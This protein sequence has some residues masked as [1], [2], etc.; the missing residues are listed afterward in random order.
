MIMREKAYLYVLLLHAVYHLY[1]PNT[2][3]LD[4]I[5]IV[6]LFCQW[7]A[8]INPKMIIPSMKLDDGTI[9]NESR[10]IMRKFDTKCPKNQQ[11]KV[12]RIMDIV[13]SCDLGWFSTVAIKKKVWLW[14]LMQ[15]SGIMCPQCPGVLEMTVRKT[16]K[17][18]AQE[19][20]DLR[21]IYLAKLEKSAKDVNAEYNI[22][23][24]APIQKCLDDLV[25]ILKERKEGEWVSGPE[26]T[27]ADSTI[28][29]YVQWAKWQIGWDA[30][31][32][33]LNPAL[34]EFANEVK[35]RECYVKTFDVEGPKWVGFYWRD[36][37]VP[38]QRAI[39]VA[40]FAVVT[41]VAYGVYKHVK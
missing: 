5:S 36:R 41:G 32:L 25:E 6:I 17:R 10:A 38:V 13:Y 35:D 27:R 23:R 20:E 9:L 22:D 14:R 1:L 34:E 28:A 31:L 7:F 33:M 12:E 11:A 39:T 40:V 26:F 37:L 16:I 3:L 29:I 30:S 15:D 2:L 18:Y 8:R 24:G 19:N 4:I 21:E